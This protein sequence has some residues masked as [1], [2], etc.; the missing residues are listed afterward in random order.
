MCIAAVRSATCAGKY[1]TPQ[2]CCGHTHSPATMSKNFPSL[3]TLPIQESLESGLRLLSILRSNGSILEVETVF[4]NRAVS[5]EMARV[6]SSGNRSLGARMLHIGWAQSEKLTVF[7]RE[8]NKEMT[9][10]SCRPSS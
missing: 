6:G 7:G 2:Q 4:Q 8:Q 1:V 9:H 5:Q 10:G 3:V